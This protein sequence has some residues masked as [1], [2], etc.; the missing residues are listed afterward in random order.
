[1]SSLNKKE[2]HQTSM[3]NNGNPSLFNLFFPFLQ[4]NQLRIAYGHVLL[5]K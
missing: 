2:N 4:S 3:F 1:M 5:R